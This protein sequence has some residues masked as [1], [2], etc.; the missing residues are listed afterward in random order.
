ML[1]AGVFLIL[2]L[3]IGPTFEIIKSSFDG[4]VFMFTHFWEM[5]TLGITEQSDFADTCLLYTS[6]SPRD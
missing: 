1:L 6:P 4:L 5:S 3:F 2:V